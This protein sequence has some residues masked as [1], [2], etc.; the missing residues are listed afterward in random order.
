MSRAVTSVPS[1]AVHLSVTPA[2]AH[3]C[4]FYRY[5]AANVGKLTGR[6]VGRVI[7]RAPEVSIRLSKITCAQCRGW[8]DRHPSAWNAARAADHQTASERTSSLF[9]ESTT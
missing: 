1:D 7:A 3:P 6:G 4:R 8:L 2:D 5:A 9:G